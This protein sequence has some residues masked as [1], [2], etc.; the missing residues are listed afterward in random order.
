MVRLLMEKSVVW[1]DATN[2]P[3][4]KPGFYFCWH[5]RWGRVVMGFADG[6][7]PYEPREWMDFDGLPQEWPS[8]DH[9]ARK[10]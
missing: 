4:E 5:E 3:P 2:E 7:G 1:R 6:W 8:P 10:K 9:P